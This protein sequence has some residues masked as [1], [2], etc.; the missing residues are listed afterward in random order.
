MFNSF[1]L[2]VLFASSTI[3]SVSAVV[4]AGPFSIALASGAISVA[5]LFGFWYI[6]R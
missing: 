1:F 4:G 6:S 5:S 2:G 3:V